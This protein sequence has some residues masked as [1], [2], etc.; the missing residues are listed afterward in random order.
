MKINWKESLQFLSNIAILLGIALVVLE[1]QQTQTLVRAQL[2]SD[3]YM[4]MLEHSNTMMGESPEIILQKACFQPET[5]TP[6]DVLILAEVFGA[7]ARLAM[8]NKDIEDIAGLNI[9]WEIMARTYFR[10]V[11]E[12][13]IGRNFYAQSK[14]GLKN[15]LQEIADE[16]LAGS[17]GRDCA[18][19]YENLL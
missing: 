10:Q 11:L 8:R 16:I 19:R 17:N 13:E 18:E 15:E 5:I 4:A 2:S 3:G 12:T 6:Q 1:L 7:K 9:D 14:R